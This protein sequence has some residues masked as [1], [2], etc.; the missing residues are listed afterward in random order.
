M[1]PFA[2]MV[3]GVFL[4]TLHSLMAIL[5]FNVPVKSLLVRKLEKQKLI[6]LYLK[7]SSSD[8]Q[9]ECSTP[10]LFAE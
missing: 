8:E 9:H 2:V 1:N 7:F 3:F 4:L 6:G 10:Y 5:P